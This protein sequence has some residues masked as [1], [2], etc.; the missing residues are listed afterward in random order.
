MP[1][2]LRCFTATDDG[3]NVLYYFRQTMYLIQFLIRFM[4]FDRMIYSNGVERMRRE[5]AHRVDP[6]RLER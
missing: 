6:P 5:H 3:R 1:T 2:P 4:S